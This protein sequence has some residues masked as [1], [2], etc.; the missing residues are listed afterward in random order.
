[1]SWL[2]TAADA[3]KSQTVK[4]TL[5]A[6]DRKNTFVFSW[7]RESIEEKLYLVFFLLLFRPLF[8]FVAFFFFSSSSFFCFLLILPLRQ[9]KSENDK[10]YKR[11]LAVDGCCC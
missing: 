11:Q 9:M 3:L 2:A 6:E 10:P 5:R 4:A 1:M 8:V 7:T